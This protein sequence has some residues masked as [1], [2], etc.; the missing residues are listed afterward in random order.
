MGPK[1]RIWPISM[2]RPIRRAAGSCRP[3]AIWPTWFSTTPSMAA[4]RARVL[5][6]KSVTFYVSADGEHWS[7]LDTKIPKIDA[8]DA[9]TLVQRIEF[10]SPVPISARYVR[11]KAE[12]YGM[13]PPDSAGAGHRA[14]LF[15]DE[16]MLR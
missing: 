13:L 12:N 1:T 7:Q 2:S 6:P 9:R 14:W 4:S 10:V 8:D 11:V 15:S 3:D 5:P 16:I